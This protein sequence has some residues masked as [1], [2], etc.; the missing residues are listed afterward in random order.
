MWI[1]NMYLDNLYPLS[2]DELVKKLAEKNIE[3]RNAFVPMN[4][5]MTLVNKYNL[6]KEEE[7]PNAN[8]IMDNGFYL[9]SGNNL[10]NGDI[11]FVCAEI[12]KHSK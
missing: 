10:T 3:T 11:D 5:Q 1:F 12:L 9:P 8:Y 7:C 4:K 2:R 6:Y